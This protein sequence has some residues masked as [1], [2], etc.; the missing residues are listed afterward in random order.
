MANRTPQQVIADATLKIDLANAKIRVTEAARTMP[1]LVD[2]NRRAVAIATAIAAEDKEG[3]PEA[4]MSLLRK[5][6]GLLTSQLGKRLEEVDA[7][8][9]KAE[10]K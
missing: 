7:A 5:V 2:L 4:E 1:F 6:Y 10:A 8:I 9:L 3:Y